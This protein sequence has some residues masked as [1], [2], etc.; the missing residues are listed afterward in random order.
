MQ[1]A[2]LWVDEA[3]HLLHFGRRTFPCDREIAA[4]LPWKEHALLLSADTDCLSLWDHDGLIRTTRVGVYPQGMA[5]AKA[6]VYVC[7]GADGKL[8]LLSLPALR[9]VAEFDMPGMPERVCICGSTA[10]VLSLLHDAEVCTALLQ[11]NLYSGTLTECTR[12]ADIPG[13][14]T[15]DQTG[16]WVGVSGLV[17]H[18]PWETDKPDM[19][20]EG[21][22]L[23]G[24]IEVR[25]GGVLITDLLEDRQL[26]IRT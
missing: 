12:F 20:V 23:P 19:I 5:I 9:K 10:W 18:I 22:G 8:H 16:L 4:A 1:H 3:A 21:I 14:L 7:G 25:P 17:V 26:F 24:Q 11:L 2:E 15:A 13:A 6:T